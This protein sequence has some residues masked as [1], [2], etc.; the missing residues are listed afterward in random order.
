MSY[1]VGL[2]GGAAAPTHLCDATIQITRV[3]AQKLVVS[4][5][6][7]LSGVRGPGCGPKSFPSSRIKRSL[8]GFPPRLPSTTNSSSSTEDS[9]RK[10]V[11]YCEH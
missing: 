1:G 7:T 4:K 10:R 8:F 2:I 6:G 11:S 3:A 9:V 5:G